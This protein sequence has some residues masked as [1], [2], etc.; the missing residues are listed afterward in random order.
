MDETNF[1]KKVEEKEELENSEKEIHES[2]KNSFCFDGKYKKYGLVDYSW[3]QK[4][5]QYLFELIDGKRNDIF[6]FDPKDAEIKR[7]NKLF[8]FKGKKH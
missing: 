7:E 6:D 2:L 3:Y 4:Y 5:K 1:Y 8:C